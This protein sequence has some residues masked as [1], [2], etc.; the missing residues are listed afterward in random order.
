MIGFNQF[1]NERINCNFSD[2]TKVTK[3]DIKNLEV[4][5][6]ILFS[7]LKIDVAFSK[8][9]F[10]RLND[11]RNKRQ[12]SV[13]ELR[14][15]FNSLYQ[16]FGIKISDVDNEVEALIKSIS[17][18]IHIPIAMHWDIRKKEVVMVAKTVMRKKGFK[19]STKRMTVENETR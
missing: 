14:G 4:E 11:E 5:L 3:G 1:L 6:G 19:S 8:H 7:S 12:I 10:D 9:F 16:K 2:D 18:N 15:I 17:T 13:C